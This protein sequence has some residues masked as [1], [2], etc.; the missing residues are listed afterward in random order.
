VASDDTNIDCPAGTC[1]ASYAY[2]TQVKL[3]ATQDSGSTFVGWSGGGCK[4]TGTC[5]VTVDSALDVTATFEKNPAASETPGQYRGAIG[6]FS[7]CSMSFYVSPNGGSIE[8]VDLFPAAAPSCLPSGSVSP[9]PPLGVAAIPIAS[10]GSFTS[11]TPQIGLV[12][13]Q[14]AT[15]TYTFNGQFSSSTALAG[16]WRVDVSYSSNGTPLS[17][18]T[19]TQTFTASWTA[20]QTSQNIA[21]ASPGSYAGSTE[22]TSCCSVR[23]YVSPDGG[24]IEDVDIPG[25]TPSCTPNGSVSPA[26]IGIASIPLN[27]DGS[28]AS[29]TTQ[30]GLVDNQ[31]AT[32]TYTFAGHVHGPAPS[33]TRARINGIWR[34]DVTY[35]NN[36][37]SFSCTTNNQSFAAEL[38]DSQTG[39][40]TATASPGRY[41]GS[42]GGVSCCSMSFYVSQDSGSIEDLDL[43]PASAPSCMPSGSVSPAPPVGI[44]SIPISGDGSFASTTT[45][46]GL[47]DNEPATFTFI[48][49]GH[50][51]GPAPSTARAR[52]D[53]IWRENVTYTNNGTSFSCTTND[54]TFAAELDA[55]QTGQ[56]N[57]TASPGSYGGSTENQ[58]CCSVFFTVSA[59]SSA[60]QNVT[61]S[62]SLMCSPAEPNVSSAIAI[63]SI[64]IDPDG[65]F[66]YKQSQSGIVNGQAATIT[67]TFNGHVHGPNTSGKTR[68]NGIWREDVTYANN[69]TS[70]YCTSNNESFAATQQ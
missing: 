11:T 21:T 62:T 41:S 3:T 16:T 57:T 15:F 28:F 46:T 37:T 39:Q 65:S 7:C 13:N 66:A 23:F 49:D 35:T 55:G 5:T 64:P 43:F 50:F 52:V 67:F 59:D 51:H 32:F 70:F 61:I 8:D 1:A 19:G 10:D 26:P 58:S 9:A 69:G 25:F 68:I 12:D 53:G 45:Q 18:S 2:G 31:P 47:V 14:P 34:E 38:D 30:A 6:G 27:S 63:P 33:T 42:I 17:C 29:T 54:H 44:A 20:G 56:T 48:L 4:G 24:S 60:I 22:N 36:G 40:S